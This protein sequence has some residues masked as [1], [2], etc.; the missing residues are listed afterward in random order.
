MNRYSTTEEHSKI[1]SHRVKR[2]KVLDSYRNRLLQY[3]RL[4]EWHSIR[5]FPNPGC[6]PLLRQGLHGIA[7]GYRMGDP[8]IEFRQ[9]N[10][11][12]RI[13]K[14]SGSAKGSTHLHSR[15]V[16]RGLSQHARLTIILHR[17]PRSRT[18]RTTPPFPHTPSRCAYG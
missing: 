4:V 12:F 10:E 2:T 17:L 8:R 16:P 11:M 13:S 3:N 18:N 5:I 1:R 6:Y 15:R 14:T 7:L 9:G